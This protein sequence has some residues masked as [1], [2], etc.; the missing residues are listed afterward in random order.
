MK[1]VDSNFVASIAKSWTTSTLCLF[2][3]LA[4]ADNGMAQS[5]VQREQAWAWGDSPN[6]QCV[7][8]RRY[9]NSTDTRSVVQVSAG[10]FHTLLLRGDGTVTGTDI[11]NYYGLQNYGQSGSP[12]GHFKWVSAGGF[13]SAGVST[14]G[15]IVAWGNYPQQWVQPASG[16]ERVEV[17]DNVKYPHMIAIRGDGS[18]HSFICPPY[19]PISVTDQA[20][21]FTYIAAGWND[22]FAIRANG[23]LW[24]HDSATNSRPDLPPLCAVAEGQHHKVFLRASDGTIL[25]EGDNSYG[26]CNAPSGR[27]VAIAAGLLF[28]VALDETGS[29]STWGRM[30]TQLCCFSSPTL[31]NNLQNAHWSMISTGEYHMAGVL[32]TCYS[33]IDFNRITDA[34][35]LSLALLDFGTC[36][37]C[38]ADLDED[39]EV[40]TADVSLLLLSWGDCN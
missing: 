16:F 6:G 31:P 14:D 36:T 18:I 34:S 27:Y 26:A 21:P 19:R 15:A 23:A 37:A 5:L 7:L 9:G 3:I 25:C 29:V 32:T 8:N 12:S 38:D 40:T 28:S 17:S 10:A 39:G 1:R 11:F 30:R 35:D 22:T 13:G 20:G 2:A 24:N 33:D 4:A